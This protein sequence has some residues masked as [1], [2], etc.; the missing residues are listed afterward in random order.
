MPALWGGRFSSGPARS[1][2]PRSNAVC[3]SSSSGAGVKAPDSTSAPSLANASSMPV[4]SVSL[5]SPAR[6]STRACAIEPR[7]S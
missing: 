6:C 7:T 5:S 2:S 4:S 3:T 1:I